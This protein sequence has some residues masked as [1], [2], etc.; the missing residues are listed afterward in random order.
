MTIVDTPGYVDNSSLTNYV[1]NDMLKKINPKN[2]IKPKT[3]QIKKGQSLIIE[4]IFRLDYVEGDR[5]SFT[6]Y[7]SNNLKV[8][9]ITTSRHDNLYEL[10]KTTYEFGYS[11]DLVINGLGFIKM[12]DKG[13]IDIYIDQKI[14]T[15][16]RSNII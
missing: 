15:F 11:K 3:Y 8:K 14:S 13:I 6:L 9:R 2:E 7:M 4:D 12:V 5:N 10:N 16:I 1:D